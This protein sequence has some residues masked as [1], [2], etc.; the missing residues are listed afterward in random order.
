MYSAVHHVFQKEAERKVA[1][2][3][4]GFLASKSWF[5]LCGGWLRRACY[6]NENI[7]ITS[8]SARLLWLLIHGNDTKRVSKSSLV[9]SPRLSVRV[10]AWRAMNSTLTAVLDSGSQKVQRESEKLYFHTSIPHEW[11]AFRS[12]IYRIWNGGLVV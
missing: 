12:K 7:P 5:Q 3:L 6:K 4:K 8:G 9:S 11:R 10:P 1:A 2:M